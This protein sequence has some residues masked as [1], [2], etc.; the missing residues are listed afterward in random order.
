MWVPLTLLVLY[1][2]L[3]FMM[4]RVLDLLLWCQQGIS[5]TVIVDPIVLSVRQLKQLLE[6]RG[7]SYT[8]Y[9]ERQELAHL[10]KASGNFSFHAK[11][12]YL[13]LFQLYT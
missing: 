2:V 6:V 9:V 1:L 10:V 13:N 12:I 11:V 5:P 3:M 4:C 8:G 7:V